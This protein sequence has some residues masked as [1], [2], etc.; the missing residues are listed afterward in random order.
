MSFDR[1]DVALVRFVFADE[2]GA[3]RRPV[4]ILSG[5][6]YHAG[7]QEMIVAAMTSNVMR[8]LPGDVEIRDWQSAGLPTP[9]VAPGSVR[10][11]KQ[12]MIER[13]IGR[14]QPADLRTYQAALRQTL[15]L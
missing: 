15:G 1:G 8:L 13:G 12:S 7:R 14:V 4:L 5:R 9:S 10:T 3:K 2:Q 6:E 11:I